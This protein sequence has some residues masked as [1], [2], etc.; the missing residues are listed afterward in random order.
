MDRTVT[1]QERFRLIET[2]AVTDPAEF[3]NA[4]RAGL[5]SSPRSLPCRFLYDANGSRI[6]EERFGSMSRFCSSVRALVVP[7]RL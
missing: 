1:P 6:F 4:V 2:Q 5:E 7:M 3:F